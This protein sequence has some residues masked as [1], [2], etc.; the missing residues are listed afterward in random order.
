MR[1]LNPWYNQLLSGISCIN[2]FHLSP[3]GLYVCLCWWIWKNHHSIWFKNG[4]YEIV[5]P[6]IQ[7]TFEWDFMH[8]C[9]PLIF[10]GVVCLFM[11]VNLKNHHSNSYMK[12]WLCILFLIPLI[13]ICFDLSFI[14]SKTLNLNKYDK[15]V[16]II[17]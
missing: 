17:H 8:K 3:L 14:S 16:S 11:L 6:L 2:V 12:W 13:I 9:F 4:T 7:S 1:I 10:I 5:K 15:F